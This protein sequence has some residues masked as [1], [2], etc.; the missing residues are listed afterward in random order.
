MCFVYEVLLILLCAVSGLVGTSPFA[1]GAD[2]APEYDGVLDALQNGQAV[3][4][5]SD[6][7]RCAAS[8]DGQSGPTVLAGMRIDSFVLVEQLGLAFSDVYET[9]D[10]DGRPVTQYIRYNIHA[11]GKVTVRIAR[12]A[13]GA[14]EAVT[15]GE[16]VCEPPDGIR[17]IWRTEAVSAR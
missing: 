3:H 7:S 13:N 2:S 10:A 1:M 17:F 8:S 12:L 15:Q 16:Y 11:D 9:L 5:L 6:F 4:A 14:P